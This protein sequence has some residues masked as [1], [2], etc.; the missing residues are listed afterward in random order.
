MWV[1]KIIIP[2]N[3]NTLI[4]SRTKKY[5]VNVKGY[6]L[7]H[8]SKNNKIYMLASVYITG[9]DKAINNFLKDLKK[10]KRMLKMDMADENFG[11]WLMEQPFEVKAFYDPLII[12]VKPII[13]AENGAYIFEIASW[14]RSKLRDVAETIQ[15]NEYHGKLISIKDE[16]VKTVQIMTAFPRLTKQQKRALELAITEG[17]YGYPR[18]IDI[19]ALA[20]I[21]KVSHSTFQFHLRNAEKKVLPYLYS[22]V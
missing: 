3:K 16:K 11:F 2:F 21:M 18:K 4:G 12:Y 7:S 1:A 10:D 8:F 9:I 22:R 17:Y 14:N 13:I 6:P 20:K 19:I 15:Q 5:K